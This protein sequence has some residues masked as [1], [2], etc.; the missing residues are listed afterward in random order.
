[1]ASIRLKDGSVRSFARTEIMGIVNVTPD[2]FYEAS[3]A[4]GQQAAAYADRLIREGADIIDVGGESTRP[5]AEAVDQEEE[6]RR[7]C[8]VIREIRRQH[9]EI[10]ISVDTYHAGTAEEAVAAGADII[11]DISAMEFDPEMAGTV[12]RLGVPVILMHTQGRPH[13]M[14][15]DPQYGDVVAEVKQ[16]LHDRIEAAERQ[17]IAR[18]RIIVDPGI[19]FGK[20]YEHNLALL[21]NLDTFNDLKV[22]VLLGASRKTVIGQMLDRPDPADR[23]YGTIAVSL[24][25]VT[26]GVDIVR[27]HDVRENAEAVRVF[28]KLQK[29]APAQSSPDSPAADTTRAFIALGSNMGDRA[30]Y[31]AKAM[32]EIGKRIGPITGRSNVIETKAYGYTEQDDFLNMAIT[33]E[34]D[35]SAHELLEELQAIEHELGRVRTIHW[36]PRTIDLDIIYY[37]NQVID[38]SDLHVPHPDLYNRE[39]VLRPLAELDS[40]YIDPRKN[41]SIGKLFEELMKKE[42]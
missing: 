3:R 18:D 12:A 21:R 4:D 32:E 11:N 24:H 22:P 13:E 29:E 23:L 38:D 19:G 35:M 10:L 26:A 40:E 41:E 7:I 25:A 5:G 36:G 30:G 16:Y 28:E 1:M 8:P 37:G 33:V 15:D 2:S 27:V 34:T 9:P 20:T 14:Q 31:L 39:F 17:G 42:G 6:C